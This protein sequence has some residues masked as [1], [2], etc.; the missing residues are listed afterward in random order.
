MITSPLKRALKTGLISIQNHPSQPQV[1][2]EPWLR[3]T[4]KSSCDLAL[5]TF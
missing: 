5:H 2:V 3:E 1:S 4:I